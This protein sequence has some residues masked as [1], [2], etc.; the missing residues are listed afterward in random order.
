VPYRGDAVAAAV[1][2]DLV[3]D[4]HDVRPARGEAGAGLRLHEAPILDLPY[5]GDA[6]AAIEQ[7][8]FSLRLLW[9]DQPNK[10]SPKL[11]I[12]FRRIFS[13]S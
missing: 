12:S 2:D 5:R 1:E 13:A 4:R 9:T 7:Q 6:V 11:K 8:S 3:S 10:Q